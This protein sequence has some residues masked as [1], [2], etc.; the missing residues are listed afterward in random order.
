MNVTEMEQREQEEKV[1]KGLQMEKL[2]EEKK[3]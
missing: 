3:G 1:I 2:K